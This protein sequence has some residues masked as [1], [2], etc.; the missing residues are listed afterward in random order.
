[1]DRGCDAVRGLGTGGTGGTG[2]G[3]KSNLS[4]R[5]D[6][7]RVGGTDIG[8]TGVQSSGEGRGIVDDADNRDWVSRV[9]IEE[10][11]STFTLPPPENPLHYCLNHHHY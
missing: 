11:E 5:L 9:E 6:L 7:G 10:M 1:M 8:R 4:E 2:T 3:T